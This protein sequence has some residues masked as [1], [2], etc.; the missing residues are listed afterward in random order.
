MMNRVRIIVK[1]ISA[2]V[3]KSLI[4]I[5]IIIIR[6]FCDAINSPKPQTRGQ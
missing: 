5:I 3:G 2:K 1:I 6:T 4:I